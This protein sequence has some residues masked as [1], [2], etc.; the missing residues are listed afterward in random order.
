MMTGHQSV[1]LRESID[2]LNIIKD[3]VYIDGTFGRGGHSCAILE[4]LGEAG[5]LIAF[6]KDPE[7]LAYA[8][9]HFCNDNDFQL[10]MLHL[11]C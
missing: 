10:Y 11:R 7:A 6:D 2:G 8:E 3:G 5:R 1:L 9:Q 4:K